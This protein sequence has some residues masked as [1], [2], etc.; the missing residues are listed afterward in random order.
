MIE[1]A[2]DVQQRAY[3]PYSHFQVGAALLCEDGT[4]YQGCNIENA[5]LTATNCA[6]RTAI[7]KAISEGKKSSV[8]SQSLAIWKGSRKA[9]AIIAHPAV[10]AGRSWRNFAI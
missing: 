1:K 9:R 7:F 8:P 10:C 6:E 3:T 2:F 4:I 5:G